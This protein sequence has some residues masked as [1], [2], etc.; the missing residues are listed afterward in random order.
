MVG[1]LVCQI[2]QS[3]CHSQYSWLTVNA[4][5]KNSCKN[6]LVKAEIR[7]DFYYQQYTQS[8]EGNDIIIADDH[9]AQVPGQERKI[10]E[11][12]FKKTPQ[13]I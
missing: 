9:S 5:L 6:G 12:K 4:C 11:N 1:Y 7:K 10:K 8:T 2:L 3:Q 13:V